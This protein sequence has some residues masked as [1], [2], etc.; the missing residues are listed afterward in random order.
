MKAAAAVPIE[1]EIER[2]AGMPNVVA[3]RLD[4]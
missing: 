1:F 3:D 4:S 2:A